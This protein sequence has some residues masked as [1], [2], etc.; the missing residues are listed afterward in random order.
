MANQEHNIRE[1]ELNSRQAAAR[2][3]VLMIAPSLDMLGGQSRQCARLRG[4]L[5]Q[6]RH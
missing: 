4:N 6:S 5:K 1:A 3:R 2:L